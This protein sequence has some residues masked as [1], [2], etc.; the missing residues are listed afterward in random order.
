MLVRVRTATV[1]GVEVLTGWTGH[2]VAANAD[3]VFLW[4]EVETGE[5]PETLTN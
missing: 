5:T 3:E 4:V 2:E 1:K